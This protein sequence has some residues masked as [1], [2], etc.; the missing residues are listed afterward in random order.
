MPE[1]PVNITRPDGVQS[2][3]RAFVL[4]ETT[5]DP[6]GGSGLTQRGNAGDLLGPRC[7]R[8]LQ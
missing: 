4:R 7:P 6:V 1:Q 3:Q 8:G 5:A 2:S